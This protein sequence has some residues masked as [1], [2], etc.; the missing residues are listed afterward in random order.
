M[1]IAYS[2]TTHWCADSEQGPG[3]DT[4]ASNASL[5]RR[6]RQRSIYNNCL[7]LSQ[8][9]VIDDTATEDN[10]KDVA[11]IGRYYCVRWQV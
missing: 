8:A 11:I 9:L 2:T 1:I 5:P 10:A 3:I 6:E 7:S 4:E